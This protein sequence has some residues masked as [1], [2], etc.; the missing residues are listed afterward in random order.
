[1]VLKNILVIKRF[2]ESLPVIHG[3]PVQL[4]Q[5]VLNLI[6]NGC[7]AMADMRSGD[8]LLMIETAQD[9]HGMIRISVTD[10]GEGISSDAEKLFEPFYTTKS[11]GLG[12]GLPICRSIVAAHGGRLWAENAKTGGAV[13]HVELPIESVGHA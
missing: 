7:E 11:L 6:I 2:A 4:R 1:L 13:F 10:S 8:R 12:L 5:V 9:G 3:D